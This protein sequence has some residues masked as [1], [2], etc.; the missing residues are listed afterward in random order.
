MKTVRNFEL[1]RLDQQHIECILCH[2]SLDLSHCNV[3]SCSEEEPESTAHLTP[4]QLDMLRLEKIKEKKLR[5]AGL[6]SAIVSDPYVNVR[7]PSAVKSHTSSLWVLCARV[8]VC[9]FC[10]TNHFALPFNIPER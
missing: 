8:C 9:S 7:R 6:G 2:L 1:L 10:H 4:E 3:F 5:I